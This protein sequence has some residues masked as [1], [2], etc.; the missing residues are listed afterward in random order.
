MKKY[1]THGITTIG[2][3][4]KLLKQKE[5]NASLFAEDSDAEEEKNF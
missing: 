4:V 2:M 1:L 3:E 5:E